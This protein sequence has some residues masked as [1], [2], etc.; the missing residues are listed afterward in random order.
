MTKQEFFE[1]I[2]E[3]I[4]D[5]IY[6][7]EKLDELNKEIELNHWSIGID[8]ETAKTIKSKDLG[9]FL[10]KVIKNRISQLDKSD[11]DMDLIFYSWFDEQA[12]NLNFNFI[13]SRH[14]NLPFSTELEFVDSLDTII[15]DFLNSRYLDGIP[16]DELEDVSEDIEE[17]DFKLKVYKEDILKS[18]KAQQCV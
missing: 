12:G 8:S 11:K 13:N 9:N 4:T 5:K 15:N 7:A 1:N 17:I 6:L 18:T 10:R 16:L 14:E 3:I 2:N